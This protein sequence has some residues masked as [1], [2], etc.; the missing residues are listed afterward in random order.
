MLEE[1]DVKLCP[2][3]LEDGG[4]GV[5]RIVIDYISGTERRVV[6]ADGKGLG[7]EGRWLIRCASESE[8]QRVVRELHRRPPWKTGGGCIFGAEAIY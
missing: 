4:V 3:D 7:A 5:E 1:L 2:R 6:K 8:A